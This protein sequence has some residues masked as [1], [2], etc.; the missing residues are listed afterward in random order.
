MVLESHRE[1]ELCGA[2]VKRHDPLRDLCQRVLYPAICV[3]LQCVLDLVRVHRAERVLRAFRQH[4]GVEELDTRLEVQAAVAGAHV[5]DRTGNVQGGGTGARARLGAGRNPDIAGALHIRLFAE[6]GMVVHEID[7]VFR[8]PT[9]VGRVGGRTRG[10]QLAEEHHV[11]VGSEEFVHGDALEGRGIVREHVVQ[12]CLL[13]DE[14]WPP[15]PRSY[16]DLR[17]ESGRGVEHWHA[18]GLCR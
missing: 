17:T 2:L 5:K 8:G 18:W 10:F 13:H 3:R 11:G 4:L 6:A 16:H 9:C 7:L 14:V 1:H 12:A 15:A